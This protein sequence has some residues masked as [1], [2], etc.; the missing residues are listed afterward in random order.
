MADLRNI[1]LTLEATQVA[2]DLRSSLGIADQM[3]IIRV[4]FAYAV[5]LRISLERGGRFGTRGG[6]NYDTGGLDVDG[7]MAETVQ[8]FY[9]DTEA[10]EEPYRAVET[11][12]NKGLRKLGEDLDAGVIG[13]ISDL[14]AAP[15]VEIIA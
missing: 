4:G 6:S 10:G 1:A 15:P 12:M 3:D 2:S 9:P 13:S 7:L 8:I 11:L 14:I 5:K